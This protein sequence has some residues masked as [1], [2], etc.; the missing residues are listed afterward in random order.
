MRNAQSAG[1]DVKYRKT[2]VRSLSAIGDRPFREIV[3]GIVACPITVRNFSLR[4]FTASIV[5]VELE[6]AAK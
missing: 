6:L 5:K 3:G 2:S 4:S 1:N